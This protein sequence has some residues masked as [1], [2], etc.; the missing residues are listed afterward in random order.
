[1]SGNFLLIYICNFHV[2]SH[3][4]LIYICK[5]HWNPRA[6]LTAV[7]SVN[8]VQAGGGKDLSEAIESLPELLAR[9]AN[10][11][12]HTNILQAVMRQVASRDVPTYYDVEQ[13]ILT[14]GQVFPCIKL[15]TTDFHM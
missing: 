3:L 13:T 2:L 5:L 8:G 12:A 15:F 14:T 4:L 7:E 6:E 10:L 9:K 1:M 11:E